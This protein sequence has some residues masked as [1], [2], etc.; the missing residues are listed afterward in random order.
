MAH[1][2][3][4]ITYPQTPK[5]A[6]FS[7]KHNSSK[8]KCLLVLNEADQSGLAGLTLSEIHQRSGVSRKYLSS[9]LGKWA[10]WHYIGRRTCISDRNQ[11]IYRYSISKR[12]FK[13]LQIVQAEAPE[14]LKLY[15]SQIREFRQQ[16]K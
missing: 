8:V 9:R 3:F 6:R 14:M 4:R 1:P 15:A 2:I 7:E 12:G 10:K 13:I 11:P 5:L 16:S